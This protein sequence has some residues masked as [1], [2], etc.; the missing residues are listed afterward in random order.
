MRTK[1]FYA[2]VL[3]MLFIVGAGMRAFAQNVAVN[4]DNSDPNPNA[5]LDV[6]SPSTGD[7]RGLLIPRM[8]QAQRTTADAS[9]AGGLLDNGGK[10]RSGTAAQ[11]LIVYQTD[12]P[13][14]I[15]YNT[16]TTSTP[17]WV[18]LGSSGTF[19]NV[20]IQEGGYV[21]IGTVKMLHKGK[22]SMPGNFVAGD[23][24]AYFSHSTGIDGYYN[25]LVGLGSGYKITDGISNT[26]VGFDSMVSGTTGDS[27]SSLGSQALY[28]NTQGSHNTAVGQN[29]LYSMNGDFTAKTASYN[30]A[31]GSQAGKLLT[32]GSYNTFIGWGADVTEA[33]GTISN[34]TAIGY[35]AK[36][37]ASNKVI[38]GNSAVTAI[39]GYVN[40]FN[41]SDS[42][43]KKDVSDC[44]VGLE[45]VER[46]RP[47]S[48]RYNGQDTLRQ[49]FVAQEVER[50]CDELGIEFG[51]LAKPQNKADRYMLSYSDFVVP[52]VNAVKT[53]KAENDGLRAENSG[54][55]ARL[56]K[57]E[58]KLGMQ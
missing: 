42:R 9:L 53:L 33:A 41:Y 43:E 18:Y 5:M 23:G 2:I 45:F 11:G 39:G 19:T 4:G 55:R 58:A 31:L 8:T 12:D 37:N 15:Y 22:D 20:T 38:I 47:V 25:T 51:G 49:G 57:I 46:L 1:D 16:S 34:A 36:V 32:T 52:L 21:M 17:N 24:G 30:T 29:A 35:N 14:G 56:E 27:N 48:F 28:T 54:L 40:W 26:S 50:A 44:H 13:Q 6:A 10:L 3:A 7:G